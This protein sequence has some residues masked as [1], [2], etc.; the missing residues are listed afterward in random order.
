MAQHSDARLPRGAS[1]LPHNAWSLPGELNAADSRLPLWLTQAEAE[2]LIA[3]CAGV[4]TAPEREQALLSHLGE[5][6]R[7]FW[8]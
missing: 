8:R 2:A 4:P 1:V 5:L 7:A 3:L 6:M